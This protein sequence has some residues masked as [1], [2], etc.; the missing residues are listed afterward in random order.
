MTSQQEARAERG[1][2]TLDSYAENLGA[3]Y[4]YGTEPEAQATDLFEDVLAAVE[5]R[6]GS[7]EQVILTIRERVGV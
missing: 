4:V 2:E 3:S 1:M 6:G 7:A 5:A